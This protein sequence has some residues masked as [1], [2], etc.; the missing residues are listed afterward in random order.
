M[1]RV[2][3]FVIEAILNDGK[4]TRIENTETIHMSNQ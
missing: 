4:N 3:K 1:N 2:L